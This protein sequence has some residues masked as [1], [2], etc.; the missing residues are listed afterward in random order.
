MAWGDG[1]PG[2]GAGG[3]SGGASWA[4][5]GTAATGASARST[6][7]AAASAARRAC[8]D[9]NPGI[10]TPYLHRYYA[11]TNLIMPLNRVS[12]A[13][14]EMATCAVRWVRDRSGT[15][16]GARTLTRSTEERW[17][18]SRRSGCGGA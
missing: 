5:T 15:R 10:A 6:T 16:Q 11:L 8:E 17:R 14:P 18:H 7:A 1:K 4:S 9:G 13:T 3:G 2:P 12:N